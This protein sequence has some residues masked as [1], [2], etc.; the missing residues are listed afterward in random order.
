VRV[1]QQIVQRRVD[2]VSLLDLVV[3]RRPTFGDTP[4]LVTVEAEENWE[5]PVREE[6]TFNGG[7]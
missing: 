3:P 1:A 7:L 2:G 4:N 5:L 6:R